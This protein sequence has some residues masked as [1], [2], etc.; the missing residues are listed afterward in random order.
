MRLLNGDF[1]DTPVEWLGKGTDVSALAGRV[2]QLVFGCGA[3]G[4]TPCSSCGNR[5][6]AAARRDP[7]VNAFEPS[8]GH[9]IASSRPRARARVAVGTLFLAVFAFASAMLSLR[10][11]MPFNHDGWYYW[12]GSV[13]L[14]KGLGYRDFTGE[15]IRD[16]PPLYSVYLALCQLVLGV[17][18]RSIGI[19]TAFAA[20]AAVASWS[21]LIAWFARECGRGPRDVLCALAFVGVVLA[22]NARNV[23]SENLFH[24]VL[25]LL[26]LFTLRAR[27]SATPGRFLLESGLAGVALL[28]SLLIRN[29]SLAFWPAVLAVLLLPPRFAWL[30]RAA[31]CGLVSALSLPIWL[32]VEAWLGQLER[33]PLQLGGNFAFGEYLLQLVLGI[34]RNTGVQS[35]GLAILVLLAAS[36]LRGDSARASVNASE[37]LGR[38]ALLFTAVA[39]CAVLAIFNLTRVYDKPESRFTL[40]VTLIIGG[41][42]LLDLPA[43]LRRRWL[44]LA[45]VVVFAEPTLRLAKNAI[46]GR[47]PLHADY[48][49]EPLKGFAPNPTTIDPAYFARAPEARGEFVL[50]SPPYPRKHQEGLRQR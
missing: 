37:R 12:Q 48:R 46:R 21:V 25:P 10:R 43:L 34:D 33:H 38:A 6:P 4:S 19:S 39:A 26:L 17:S 28:I 30:T 7:G 15:P 22:L 14:L 5:K 44:A 29:A 16:W 49:A 9:G 42:G 40:F 11:G 8:S 36:L 18:A 47:G 50:V 35:M 45:L 20:A 2:V 1:L 31:A 32:A 13:S 24:A 27:V 41:L 3:R 23:R